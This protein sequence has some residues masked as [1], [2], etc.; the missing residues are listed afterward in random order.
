MIRSM[1][2]AGLLVTSGAA[3]AQAETFTMWIRG[4]TDSFASVADVYNASHEH[5]VEFVAV[6]GD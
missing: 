3:S 6:P 2:I 5:Q 4:T 1:T